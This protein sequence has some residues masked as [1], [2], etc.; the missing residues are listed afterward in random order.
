MKTKPDAIK[1]GN[2][3]HSRNTAKRYKVCRTVLTALRKISSKRG[4]LSRTM[5]VGMELLALRKRNV[6]LL[7]LKGKTVGHTFKIPAH[8]VRQINELAKRYGTR[9]KVLQA[10][11]QVMDAPIAGVLK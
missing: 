9:G 4:G 8:T 2:G 1:T 5:Q 7:K 3:T 10:M 11:A 6:R